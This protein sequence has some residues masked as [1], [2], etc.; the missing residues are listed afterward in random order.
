MSTLT[1]AVLAVPKAAKLARC[2]AAGAAS[3]QLELFWRVDHDFVRLAEVG[4][5]GNGHLMMLERN[6]GEIALY[7]AS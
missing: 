2:G 5:S 6:N 1:S 4:I 3:I 7:I